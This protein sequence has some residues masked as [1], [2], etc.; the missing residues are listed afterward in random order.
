MSSSQKFNS[1]AANKIADQGFASWIS[2]LNN[3][4]RIPLFEALNKLKFELD[5]QDNA[6]S[7]A[8]KELDWVREKIGTPENILGSDRTK[9]GEIA[10]IAE[11]GIR[12]AK[13]LIQGKFPDAFWNEANRFGPDDYGIAG[14]PV[15]SKFINGINNGLRHIL[16]HG[17]KYP[18][19]GTLDTGY[20]H[21][22]KDQHDIIQKILRGDTQGLNQRSVNSILNK[23]D[24]L[25]ELKGRSFTD[26]V[27]PATHRYSDVQQGK[28][29]ETIKIHESNLKHQNDG[30]KN[31]IKNENK[32]NLK[33]AQ[34]KA[35]PTLGELGKVTATGAAVGAGLQITITVYDKWKKEGKNPT[36]FTEN[37]WKEI[38]SKTGYGA[39]IGGISA[40]SLYGL[41][42]YSALSAPFAAAVVSSGRGMV[43]LTKRYLNGEITL[44][45]Y[46][47][48]SIITCTE[49]G[50]VAAGAAL[51]QT[52]IP[53][54][55]L[56]AVIG[57]SIAQL[58]SSHAKDLLGKEADQIVKNLE[59]KFQN[60]IN[61][62]S[63]EHQELLV[64]LEAKLIIMRELTLSAFDL[65]LNSD[66]LLQ[67]SILLAENYKVDPNKIVRTVDDV[68]RFILNNS[69]Y[70]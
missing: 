16:D 67:N 11:V 41:T 62:L 37:D 44:D 36:Q 58:A 10:E 22:P 33:S 64:Q 29:H 4:R 21:I 54:P 66:L 56:G 17:T 9:H 2:E 39:S 15:Q 50:I 18:N 7:S 1:E 23:I 40:A 65:N 26:L 59:L 8:L 6:F 24:D 48:L 69:N 63:K 35:A 31:D 19:Y 12:R 53:I 25:E 28:I 32:E 38:G 5:S 43:S 57:S 20:Y 45:E 3:E 47:D 55:V 30:I 51:G 13:D 60:Q 68:D 46:T 27:R 61:Q 14:D 42:N 70:K 49:A 34:E 52:I